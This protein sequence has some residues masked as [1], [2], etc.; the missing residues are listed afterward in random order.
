MKGKPQMQLNG[1]AALVTGGATGMGRAIARRLAQAGADVAICGLPENPLE[2]AAAELRAL[3]VRALALETDQG[4]AADC[5]EVVAR[6]LREFGRLDILVNSAGALGQIG[7][8]TELDT[9][10]WEAAMRVNLTGLMVLC[11]ESVKLMLSAGRGG[12]IINISSGA[13]RRPVPHRAPYIAAKW[14]M[15]GFGQA[16]AMEVGRQNIRVNAILPGAVATERFRRMTAIMAESRGTTVDAI[17]SGWEAETPA[18][19]FVTVEEIADTA[20]YLASDASS[21]LTGQAL[22]LSA[23]QAM[24]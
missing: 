24:T 3:G 9:E 17:I 20:L 12:S 7:P 22:N 11:R 14:A 8:V 15:V 21:G 19:R 5:E 18:G 16:L 4:I 1:R 10:Q 23:G 13:V 6:T 2:E